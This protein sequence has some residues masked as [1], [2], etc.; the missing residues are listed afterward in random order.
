MDDDVT[1][2]FPTVLIQVPLVHSRFSRRVAV[3]QTKKRRRLRKE[4]RLVGSAVLLTATTT[5][6]VLGLSGGIATSR[7]AAPASSPEGADE[8][9]PVI[10]LSLE[11]IGVGATSVELAAPVVRTAGYV[12]PD[13]GTEE[14]SHAGS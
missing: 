10:S 5:F 1:P 4:V 11:P 7:S 6:G 2:P 12:L 9:P 3:G 14:V 8:P 13:D